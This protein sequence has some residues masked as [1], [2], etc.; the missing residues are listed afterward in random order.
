MK[1]QL[2]KIFYHPI[3]NSFFRS[4]LKLFKGIL[5]AG[6]KIPVSGVI[7][8]KSDKGDIKFFTNETSPMTKILFWEDEGCTFEFSKIFKEI[9]PHTNTF[10]DIGANVGYYSLLAQK[11][12]PAIAIHSFEPS[13]GPKYFLRKNCEIN[14]FQDIHIV[15]KALGN[16]NGNIEFFEEKNPKYAY[17]KHHASGIGN[18]ANTWGIN[19]YLKYPVELIRLDDYCSQQNIATI[20]LIKIDTEGTEDAVFEGGL[21]IIKKSQPII[22][23]EVLPGK[24]E[25]KIQQ[26]IELE[27]KFEIFQFQSKTNRLKKITKI[28]D[29]NKNGETNYFFV[30]TSK[31]SL[32]QPFVD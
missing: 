5:P 11:L 30:P 21:E 12:N 19:N 17:Q 28:V 2:Y 7:K 22:I 14:G 29:E 20:D 9:I 27:F 3:V 31:L 6:L 32:I 18:T 1:Q 4:I 24:I 8:I 13:A 16:Y 23:C 25:E 26:I 10:F 15:E